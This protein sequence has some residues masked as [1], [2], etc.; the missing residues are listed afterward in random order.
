MLWVKSPLAYIMEIGF[1]FYRQL[2]HVSRVP[3]LSIHINSQP[4]ITFDLEQVLWDPGITD[5]T[6]QT[7]QLILQIG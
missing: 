1:R 3:I 7:K 4:K 6:Q 5:V 2:S